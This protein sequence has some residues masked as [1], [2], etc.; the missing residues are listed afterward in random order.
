FE[1]CPEKHSREERKRHPKQWIIKPCITVIQ[2]VAYHGKVHAPDHQR[3]CLG[4]H[5]KVVVLEESS[6]ALVVNLIELHAAKI[7][8]SLPQI[9]DSKAY[10]P[11]EKLVNPHESIALHVKKIYQPWKAVVEF[12]RPPWVSADVYQKDEPIQ[13][14]RE[15]FLS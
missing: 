10:S 8:K 6:L 12:V 11:T 13:A 5:F 14:V 9:Y 15:P 7:I 4:E 1:E 3:V 2:H